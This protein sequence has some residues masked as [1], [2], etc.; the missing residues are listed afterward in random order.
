[1][2]EYYFSTFKGSS[3]NELVAYDAT[4][5]KPFKLGSNVDNR[6]KQLSKPYRFAHRIMNAER[7]GSIL[8]REFSEQIAVAGG[9]MYEIDVRSASFADLNQ[10]IEQDHIEAIT[11]HL[12]DAIAYKSTLL[13]QLSEFNVELLGEDFIN[14]SFDTLSD[15]IDDLSSYCYEFILNED[16][17]GNIEFSESIMELEEDDVR[18]A[19]IKKVAGDDY[20]TTDMERAI[21]DV[22]PLELKQCFK[23]LDF[24]LSL[25]HSDSDPLTIQQAYN[26][27]SMALASYPDNELQAG[28]ILAD[29]VGVDGYICTNGFSGDDE[30]E[31][32]MVN[33]KKIADLTFTPIATEDLNYRIYQYS[34]NKVRDHQLANDNVNSIIH[35]AKVTDEDLV[36]LYVTDTDDSLRYAETHLAITSEDVSVTLQKPVDKPYIE[37]LAPADTFEIKNV[38]ANSASID[39]N[40]TE[41]FI[42]IAETF[43]CSTLPKQEAELEKSRVRNNSMTY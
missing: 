40:R 34:T 42:D 12:Y 5:N 7:V 1:M 21:F 35:L 15:A 14:E 19:F 11:M 20:S 39:L 41:E 31:Y 38:D 13:H 8:N 37:L 43:V 17:A 33:P 3:E 4:T 18:S 9:V 23:S 25:E 2:A 32:L 6:L 36:T 22:L 29:A 26:D 10:A 28:T 16:D 27:I 24:N 30:I